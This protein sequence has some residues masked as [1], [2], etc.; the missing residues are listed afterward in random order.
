MTMKA[1]ESLDRP[2]SLLF[3]ANLKAYCVETIDEPDGFGQAFEE[4][5]NEYPTFIDAYLQFWK[6]LKFRLSQMSGRTMDSGASKKMMKKRGTMSAAA[7][8]KDQSGI[9][10]I[11]K[12]HIVAEQALIQSQCT[13][14]PTS[15]CVE[16]RIIYAKQMLYE[17]QVAVAVNILH[18]ICY[19]LPQLPIDDLSYIDTDQS[20]MN[21]ES[22]KRN[23]EGIQE[24]DEDSYD[25]EEREAG[26]K[27]KP[28]FHKNLPTGIS[29]SKK[30][31]E[32]KTDDRA[33]KNQRL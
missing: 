21:E 17:K 23:L 2:N 19:I 6:Y 25:F 24:E 29:P 28:N 5:I 31:R 22:V 1:I 4:L 8:V 33:L 32:P 10:I 26:Q 9:V 7:D 14:V 30:E 15:L 20:Q 18:D 13:E 12:M 16:A 27:I 3:Q 11:D